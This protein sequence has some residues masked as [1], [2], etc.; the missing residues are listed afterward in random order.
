M[1]RARDHRTVQHPAHVRES[2]SRR[3]KAKGRTHTYTNTHTHTHTYSDS[4][5]HVQRNTR[6]FFSYASSD[7]FC[8]EVGERFHD[9]FAFRLPPLPQRKTT[10]TFVICKKPLFAMIT[11]LN[12]HFYTP[13]VVNK[14]PVLGLGRVIKIAVRAD[15]QNGLLSS[16]L[17]F[18]GLALARR[19][20]G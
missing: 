6:I 16:S 1:E 5:K 18:A 12:L 2:H 3:R 8:T 7:F 19:H 14:A 10:R 11:E 4:H 17:R 15:P 9:C 13:I 20:N